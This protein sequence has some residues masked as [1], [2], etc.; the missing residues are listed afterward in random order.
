MSFGP[1]CGEAD[2]ECTSLYVEMQRDLDFTTAVPCGILTACLLKFDVFRPPGAS[3]L[4]AVVMIPGGPLPPGNRTYMWQLARYV[5]ARGAI[6]FTADYRSGASYGGGFPTTFADVACAVRYARAHA[7]DF[8]GRVAAPVTLVAHSFGGFPG[9]VVG[10]SSTDFTSSACLTQSGEGR[11][12]A[13]VGIAGVY[14]VEDIGTDFLNEFFGG[15]RENK[16]AAWAAGDTSLLAADAAA[17][18]FPIRLV[19]GSADLVGRP[20]IAS[21]FAAVLEAAG[22]EV[23]L[24]TVDGANHDSIL[25]KRA[26]VDV[27]ASLLGP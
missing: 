16:P 7:V 26:T 4:P 11:P 5:A 12:D 8:G 10:L 2:P 27:I 23:E 15:T 14:R 17:H 1:P 6:V 21:A 24:S 9:S 25:A 13:L 20:E 22:Q 18:R 3:E 19:V